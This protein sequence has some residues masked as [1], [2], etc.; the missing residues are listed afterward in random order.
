MSTSRFRAAVESGDI[1]A[2]VALL[3]RDVV[4]HSP[5]VFT[6]YTDFDSVAVILRAVFDVF[7][8]FR[9]TDEVVTTDREVLVFEARVGDRAVEGVDIIRLD[10]GGQVS[11]LTVM[12]R[13][14][15]GMMALAEAMR[16]RLARAAGS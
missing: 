10:D 8:D 12:V 5:I 2:V 1:D 16:E 9:Y 13:P 3:A 6:P 15:T 14:M 11:A 7:E 4:F